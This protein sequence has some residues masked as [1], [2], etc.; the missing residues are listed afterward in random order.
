MQIRAPKRFTLI[1]ERIYK[2]YYRKKQFIAPGAN[3]YLLYEKPNFFI[4]L[5][6]WVRAHG[7]SNDYDFLAHT[8]NATLNNVRGLHDAF[9]LVMKSI[10]TPGMGDQLQLE[11]VSFQDASRKGFI[12]FNTTPQI[13]YFDCN[14]IDS[15]GN[16]F[17][18]CIQD[19]GATLDLRNVLAIIA[20]VKKTNS[21]QAN[22]LDFRT[23]LR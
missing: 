21:Q 8:M 7:V 6:P 11:I 3:I 10:F 2:A 15:K 23:K 13:N 22:F 5:F 9:F 1:K 14:V 12:T 4:N 17:K 16:F 20:S 18:I 19:Q